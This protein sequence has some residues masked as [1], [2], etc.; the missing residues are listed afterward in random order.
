[1]ADLAAMA[2][3]GHL[4]REL[5]V[6]DDRLDALADL[7]AED[8]RH[9]RRLVAESLAA[10]HR[11]T[12]AGMA[13]AAKLLP[14]KLLPPIAE[15]AIGPLICSKIAAE[16]DP[17]HAR[18]IVGSFSVPF[19][20]DL[21]RTLD[22]AAAEDVVRAI[23]ADKA[24]P[25]G[26]ELYE[27]GDVETVGRFIDVVHERAIPPMLEVV[28]DDALLRIAIVAERRER[29]STI[30]ADL[31]DERVL[32]LVEAGVRG[33]MLDE[34]L[35]VVAELDETQ[36]ARTVEIVVGG[37][38]ALLTDVVAAIAGLR[39]WDRL[40]PVIAGLDPELVA[41]VA[42]SPVVSRPDVFESIV[43]HAAEADA[44]DDFVALIGA[45]PVPDQEAL[46]TALAQSAPDVA[47]RLVEVADDHGVVD[48]PA[49]DVL[50]AAR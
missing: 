24:V 17:A 25:V 4:A 44:V 31:S 13:K 35:V 45:L 1:M 33:D 8:L 12:F 36:L 6:D 22:T 14:A 5:H 32:Q 26:I 38:D 34:A 47:G 9:L 28:D 49:L 7:A 27:R 3:V 42:S 30:F 39:A 21:C 46:A 48:L 19:L 18:K 37:G 10:R 15:R 29:L 11:S 2:E 23:P 50:R 40:L 16:L 41:A 43:A 20:A